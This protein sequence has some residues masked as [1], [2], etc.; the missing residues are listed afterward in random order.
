MHSSYW[1]LL[2]NFWTI[3]SIS[4][5]NIDVNSRQSSSIYDSLKTMKLEGSILCVCVGGGGGEGGG[6]LWI[7]FQSD[8][9]RQS[10]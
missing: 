2:T 4:G 9:S 1:Y 8:I 5:D 3:S 10:H 7:F 6:R